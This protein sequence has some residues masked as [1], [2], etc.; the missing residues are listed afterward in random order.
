MLFFSKRACVLLLAIF[1]VS[2]GDLRPSGADMRPIVTAGVTGVFTNQIA[3]DFSL[4]DSNGNLFTLSDYVA[5]GVKQS[6]AVVL[7]FTMWC[8]V[9]LAHSDH[10]L[11][12]LMPKFAKRG[13]VKYVLIDYVSGSVVATQASEAANGYRGS[14]F[15][16]LSD[17]QQNELNRW[18]AAMGTVIVLDANGTVLMNEDYKDGTRTLQILSILLP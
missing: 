10:I 13:N 12:Q 15:I 9:C 7:Y 8:P 6:D 14:P 5:G 16:S 18:H 17:D 2:C 3:P 1:V 4:H 11:Y